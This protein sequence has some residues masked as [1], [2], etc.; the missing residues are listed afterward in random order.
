MSVEP[1]GPPYLVWGGGSS[2]PRLLRPGCF[3]SAHQGRHNGGA[4]KFRLRLSFFCSALFLNSSYT[5][6]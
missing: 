2:Q 3:I 1:F 6:C 4:A 5:V